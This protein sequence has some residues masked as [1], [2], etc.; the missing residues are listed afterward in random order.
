VDVVD[1]HDAL[2]SECHPVSVLPWHD[3]GLEYLKGTA[4]YTE[5]VMCD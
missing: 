1:T 2:V 4:D 3:G 5:M